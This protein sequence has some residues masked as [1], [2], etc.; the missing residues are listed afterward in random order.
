[1]NCVLA[2]V[3]FSDA[4][5]GVVDQAAILARALGAELVILH[6]AAPDPDFV[7][8]ETGPQ[9]VRDQL[10][11]H[12]HREHRQ[13]QDW[14]R[15]T[16]ERV[17]GCRALLVR[18]PTVEKILDQ[19]RNLDAGWVVL[20]SHGHG[21]LHNLLV[22]SAAEGVLRQSPVPVVVVPGRAR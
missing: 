9:S 13:L 20:G 3:D 16:R 5:P 8:Y 18:G 22:G 6:V 11:E 21:A 7:G 15:E 10:A 2:A 1:M 17:P 19:V 12:Y 4:T 14:E